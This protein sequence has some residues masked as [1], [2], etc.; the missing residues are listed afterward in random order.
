M[1]LNDDMAYRRTTWALER[2][3]LAWVRTS[4]GMASAAIALDKGAT[5]LNKAKLLEGAG[6]VEGGFWG[7]IVLASYAAVQLAIATMIYV[8]RERELA[9]TAQLPI[10]WMPVAVPL[11]VLVSLSCVAITVMLYS[12]I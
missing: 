1:N 12:R 6:W 10:P 11:S 8:R 3:Q 5:A 9:S 4:F 7:G 2:T